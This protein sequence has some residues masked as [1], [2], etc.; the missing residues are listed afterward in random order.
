MVAGGIA[1]SVACVLIAGGVGLRGRPHL[2]P[3]PRNSA[4]GS[5]CRPD[6]EHFGPRPCPHVGCR[7]HLAELWGPETP[8][9][10]PTCALDVAE[11]GEHSVEDLAS[12]LGVSP[13]TLY[14]IEA[15]AKANGLSQ[16]LAE[17]GSVFLY[18]GERRA[19]AEQMGVDCSR[20]TGPII[21]I[22]YS[23]NL[24]DPAASFLA[25]RL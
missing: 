25:M 3:R 9:N 20:F 5:R 10:A 17:P 16:A 19:V 13:S 6:R 1:G 24:R 8:E 23:I 14:D 12:L 15:V 2:E 11:D 7:Y 18:R 21:P 22:I 4:P